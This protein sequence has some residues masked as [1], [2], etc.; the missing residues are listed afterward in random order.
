M[1]GNAR[2][3]RIPHLARRLRRQTGQLKQGDAGPSEYPG[4]QTA[5]LTAW[6]T[7]AHAACSHNP[8]Y[9]VEYLAPSLRMQT[10]SRHCACPWHAVHMRVSY[11]STME[12]ND[13]GEGGWLPSSAALAEVLGAPAAWLAPPFAR[14]PPH[15]ACE[16]HPVSRASTSC[17]SKCSATVG[18][19]QGHGKS[20][21]LPRVLGKAAGLHWPS[22]SP[23]LASCTDAG[24]VWARQ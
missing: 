11:K 10:P 2:R 18:I 16:A 13:R 23:S 1:A 22:A 8:F 5:G 17:N 6:S 4:T 9:M 15:P 21:L 20:V 3:D 14:W 24:T 19:V 12:C 7:R